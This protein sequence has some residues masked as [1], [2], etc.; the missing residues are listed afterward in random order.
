[1]TEDVVGAGGDRL[2]VVHLELVKG[3]VEEL[4]R[5]LEL[6]GFASE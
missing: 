3:P 2:R 5:V 6:P 1:M 4:H